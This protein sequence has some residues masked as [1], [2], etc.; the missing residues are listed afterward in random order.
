M[1]LYIFWKDPTKDFVTDIKGQGLSCQQSFL[2]KGRLDTSQGRSR[3]YHE[4]VESRQDRPDTPHGVPRFGMK[5]RHAEAQA[6]VGLEAS[7]WSEH[8]HGRGLHGVVL[9]KDELAVVIA[10]FV[11]RVLDALQYIVPLQNVGL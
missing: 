2:R 11:R 3:L 5:V 8:Q 1:Q 10:A 9:W 4:G 6:A 7:R